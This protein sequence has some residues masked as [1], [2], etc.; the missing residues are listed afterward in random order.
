[1][2]AQPTEDDESHDDEESL[3]WHKAA[4]KS[5]LRAWALVKAERIRRDREYHLGLQDFTD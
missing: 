2:S 5:L 3:A 1:M 4:R